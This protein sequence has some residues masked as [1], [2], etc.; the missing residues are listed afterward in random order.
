MRGYPYVKH[1]DERFSKLLER[2]KKLYE[3]SDFYYILRTERH[4]APPLP[5]GEKYKEKDYK[6]CH[7]NFPK[8]GKPFRTPEKPGFIIDNNMFAKH[9]IHEHKWFYGD[10]PYVDGGYEQFG[11]KNFYL[12]YPPHQDFKCSWGAIDVDT[13]NDEDFIKRLVKH[14]YDEKPPLVP[15]FS[16]SK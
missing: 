8:V 3:G 16:K 13:Y 1:I 4:Y 15:V 7:N 9:L 6:F 12:V 2:F 14:I 5:L 11:H 10:Q